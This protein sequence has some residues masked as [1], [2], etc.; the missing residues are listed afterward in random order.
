MAEQPAPRWFLIVQI[1]GLAHTVLEKALSTGRM[2]TLA[3]L[4]DREGFRLQRMPVGLP[5]S[6]PAFQAAQRAPDQYQS[7][8]GCPTI[9][10][11]STHATR[12]GR[13][14]FMGSRAKW[15]QS[16]RVY[17]ATRAHG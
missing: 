14:P 7:R 2:P 9:A 15:R 16:G 1:D 17:T 4:L 12:I 13:R 8:H 6:T 3:R 11:S 5:T 10:V